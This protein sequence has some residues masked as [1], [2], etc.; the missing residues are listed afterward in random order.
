MALNWT[1]LNEDGTAPVPL[2]SEKV[3]FF[4]PGC[5]LNLSFKTPAGE[6]KWKAKGTAYVT[7]QRVM[8]LRQPLLPPHAVTSDVLQSLSVPLSNFLDTRYM[9]PVFSAPYYEAAIIPVPGGGLP[10]VTNTA[11]AS[12]P[13]SANSPA[14][15]MWTMYFN[16]G[17]GLEFRSAVEEVKVRMEEMHGRAQHMESLPLYEPPAPQH[18]LAA[19]SL[20][21]SDAGAESSQRSQAHGAGPPAEPAGASANASGSGSA[22]TAASGILPDDDDLQAAQ[23][24]VELEEREREAAQRGAIVGQ[25]EQAQDAQLS[26]RRQASIL[27]PCDPELPPA[28]DDV[29]TS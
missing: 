16:E 2:P 27:H 7:N 11:S 29:Y 28:Y 1:M 18:A 24:V 22:N 26:P 12:S 25:H 13:A 14:K 9:I 20:S 15:G 8:F 6:K 21:T 4:A 10:E 5:E 23:V 3:F 19:L 17:R